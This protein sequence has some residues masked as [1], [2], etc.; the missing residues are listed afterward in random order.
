MLTLH[1]ASRMRHAGF[2]PC[3]EYL[4]RGKVQKPARSSGG[5]LVFQN[6]STHVVATSSL[7]PMAMRDRT[8]DCLDGL[9]FEDRRD[10]GWSCIRRA[11]VMVPWD[12]FYSNV[13]LTSL[14]LVRIN[15]GELRDVTLVA[16][17]RAVGWPAI[18]LLLFVA[19]F[20]LEAI[21]N[22]ERTARLRTFMVLNFVVVVSAAYWMRLRL[23]SDLISKVLIGGA[24][25]TYNREA[26][27]HRISSS[28]PLRVWLRR[29][30][31]CPP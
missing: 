6:I 30:W 16:A 21:L 9:A 5:L 26:I 15:F 4:L 20:M 12:T 31:A 28:W 18:G 19:P 10:L 13:G 23:P 7:R 27:L 17:F 8:L 1:L 25:L 3:E 11:A 29:M 22:V 24:V 2:S 14:E